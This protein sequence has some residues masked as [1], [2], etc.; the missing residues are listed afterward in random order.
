M[1]EF[2]MRHPP[3]HFRVAGA[4]I[5]YFERVAAKSTYF[6]FRVEIAKRE[7]RNIQKN[8][9]LLGVPNDCFQQ[10]ARENIWFCLT[11]VRTANLAAKTDPRS[12]CDGV[13]RAARWR[14]SLIAEQP[15][16]S[17]AHVRTPSFLALA[18]RATFRLAIASR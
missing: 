7:F 3:I 14:A 2:A 4:P 13:S 18:S 11:L 12:C 5:L 17:L 9:H 6:H 1:R 16:A 15:V 10:D 8:C